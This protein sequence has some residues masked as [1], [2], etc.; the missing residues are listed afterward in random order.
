MEIQIV[1]S[2]T[3]GKDYKVFNG[4]AYNK[5]TSDE[6]IKVLDKYLQGYRDQRIRL[7]YGDAKTG[8]DWNEE[9]DVIG[10]LGRSTGRFKIPL[11]IAK[12]HSSGG[13]AIL[14]NC[15]VKIT[16]DKRTVYQHS[17]YHS[18]KFD[19]KKIQK[20]DE[21]LFSMG[22]RFKVV[23]NGHENVANF[24]EEEKANRYIS[25]MKGERNKVA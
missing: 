5:N 19:I 7:F 6:V 12:S 25:F 16:V 3:E 2:D 14:D 20:R 23:R 9:Y 17:K 11:L 1:K 22:Y 24:K 10:Y 13:P 8:R 4:T 21:S 18:N 15:I